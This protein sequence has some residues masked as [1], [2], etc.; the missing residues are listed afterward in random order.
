MFFDMI[1]VATALGKLWAVQI[2]S[3]V[4]ITGA[5]RTTPSAA[6]DVI[7]HLLPLDLQAKNLAGNSALRLT[8]LGLFK[9][10][11]IGHCSILNKFVSGNSVKTD[12]TT[13]VFDFDTPYEI[14]YPGREYWRGNAIT[15]QK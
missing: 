1:F 3:S 14:T 5:L 2:T 11:S 12:D 8:N 10:S 13:P 7:L 4:A 15:K 9:K 6:L